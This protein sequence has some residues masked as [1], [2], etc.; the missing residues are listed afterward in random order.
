MSNQ[1]HQNP[2][3]SVVSGAIGG[4]YA[5]LQTNNF[6]IDG[7][8]ELLKV[9]SFAFIGGMVGY[10]GKIVAERWHKRLKEEAKKVCGTDKKE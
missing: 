7:F 5:F 3:F 9:V 10:F 1:V 8:L 6:I 2:L 4:T